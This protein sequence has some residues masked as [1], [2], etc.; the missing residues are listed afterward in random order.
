MGCYK[1]RFREITRSTISGQKLIRN[2]QRII[3]LPKNGESHIG[4]D[5]NLQIFIFKNTT[6]FGV[7]G[8]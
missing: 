5:F 2:R 8:W 6:I 3:S 4:R 1:V 7:R